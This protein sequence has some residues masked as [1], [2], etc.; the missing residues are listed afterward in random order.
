[1]SRLAQLVLF[2]D[3]IAIVYLSIDAT[4]ILIHHGHTHIWLTWFVGI[5]PGF[6][7]PFFTSLRWL[8]LGCGIGAPVLAGLASISDLAAGRKVKDS[9]Y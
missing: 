4:I 1:M 5:L 8:Y 3:G 9:E 6:A 2:L 7:L